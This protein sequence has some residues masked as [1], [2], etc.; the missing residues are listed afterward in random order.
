MRRQFTPSNETEL[1][2][3]WR[4]RV[5]QTWNGFIKS[6]LV[7][8]TSS[9]LLQRLIRRL[10]AYYHNQTCGWR[11]KPTSLLNVAGTPSSRDG[12]RKSDNTDGDRI[13]TPCASRAGRHS[14][15]IRLAPHRE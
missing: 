10:A 12:S 6:N 11:G 13:Q 1:S 14:Q 7:I 3:R 9:G 5:W 15:R 4:E 2:H 8:A